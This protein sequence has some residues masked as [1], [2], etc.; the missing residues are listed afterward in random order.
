[1]LLCKNAICI[2]LPVDQTSIWNLLLSK[3]KSYFFIVRGIDRATNTD[4]RFYS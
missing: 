2:Y 3:K 1:M 4:A